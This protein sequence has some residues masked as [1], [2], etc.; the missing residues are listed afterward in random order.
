M[1]GPAGDS[2]GFGVGPNAKEIAS[3]DTYWIFFGSREAKWKF[4]YI[5]SLPK[6]T[7]E[8]YLKAG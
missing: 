1:R 3:G 5:E 7:L 4:R 8:P 6:M 2:W